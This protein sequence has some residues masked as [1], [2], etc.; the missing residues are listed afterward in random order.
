[1]N[2]LLPALR[3][4]VLVAAIATFAA[5]GCGDLLQEP[6]SGTTPLPVQLEVVSGN[7]QVGSAGAAL[8]APVRVRVVD[9]HGEPIPGLWA[10]WTVV[11]GSGEVAARHTFSDENGIAETTWILGPETGLQ[12]VRVFV[13]GGA[14]MVFD[15]TALAE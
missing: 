5:T 15:A 9:P 4:R 8:A 1:M 14:P 10:E 13:N 12:R 3:S 11:E 2:A 6:E 7:D